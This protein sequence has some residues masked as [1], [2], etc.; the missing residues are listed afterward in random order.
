MHPLKLTFHQYI[1][2]F[3]KRTKISKQKC[4]KDWINK[5]YDNSPLMTFIIQCHNKS[6]EVKYIVSKLRRIKSSE[7]IVIDDGSS[8]YHAKS[9]LGFFNGVN[10]FLIH[11]NDLFENV[12]YDRALRFANGKYVVL[13]QDDDDFDNLQ[14][15]NEAISYFE[16]YPNM[17]ILGGKDGIDFKVDFQKNDLYSITRE[18]GKEKFKF[19]SS[20]DRAPMWIRKE[21]FDDILKHIDYNFAPFQFDDNELCLR[22]WL[23]NLQV[24]WYDAKFKS[25][26]AGGMRIWNTKFTSEQC[27]RNIKLLFN[28]YKDKIEF[29]N[30][31]V[32]S[33]NYK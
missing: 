29:I 13:M 24:G 33:A 3:E 17:A 19:V 8:N 32:E 11:T 28:L 15:I 5:G 4:R 10:E 22:A 14:W 26:S 12:T 9:F 21:Q 7:I 18:M 31:L 27:E 20:V 1:A 25:I 16:K 6:D 23:S 2:A 30:V